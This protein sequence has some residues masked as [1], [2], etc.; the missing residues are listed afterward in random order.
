MS[1]AKNQHKVSDELFRLLI[2]SVSDYAIYMIG[3]DGE[4]LTWNKGAEEIKGY[5]ADEIIGKNFSQF[6]TQVDQQA[7]LPA[8]E[9]KQA[10]LKGR[11]EDVAWRVRKDNTQFFAKISITPLYN[12]EK[13]LRG[14]AKITRDMTDRKNSDDALAKLK[15]EEEIFRPLV[16]SVL[17][18]AII[19]LNPD[20]V[21]I[22]WNE[23]AKRITGYSADEIT[24]QS[25]TR[26]Y[27]IEATAAGKPLQ[28]LNDAGTLGRFDERGWRVRQDGSQFFAHITT[29]PLRDHNG[30]L[31]GFAEVFRDVT[32]RKEYED[33]QVQSRHELQM[34]NG[35]LAL[36]RDQAQAASKYKS[37]F[38]ANMSHEI[39]TPLN[40]IIGMCNVLLT[41]SMSEAQTLYARAI[42]TA[43]NSLLTIINDILDFS[44]IEAGR[45]DLERTDFSPVKV[46]ET[47]C[48]ILAN[49]AR[50]KNLTL[51]SFIDPSMPLRLRGDQE[52]VQQIL[53][54]FISNA[55]KFSQSGE[56]IVKAVVQTTSQDKVNVRF[57]VTDSG[58]GLTQEQQD[59]LFQPFMQADGTINRRFG[60]TGLGLSISKQLVE[61]MEGTIGIESIKDSGSTFWFLVPFECCAPGPSVTAQ[62][63][64]FGVRSL[65]VDDEP[66][67]REIVHH[68]LTSWGLR[69]DS[70][71]TVEAGM[72]LLRA[73][74]EQNDP[75]KIVIL[76]LSMPHK[77]GMDMAK[78]VFEDPSLNNVH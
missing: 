66:N 64:L 37:E 61:L 27:T 22:T 9:L 45:I 13:Q 62:A 34:L 57:S 77:N 59:K 51:M 76:D 71:S 56:V 23:G 8:F 50:Q 16:S 74:V 40:G 21:I 65:N 26:L 69:N 11:F 6:Y 30:L 24:G 44:K 41:T 17:D 58:I 47:A 5:L 68:Y 1:P 2:T 72:K 78:E 36:A 70:V 35:E 15:E 73:G 42:K 55:I 28:E 19:V 38:V 43:G 10:Q 53:I 31:R 60:G 18:Y 63:E 67:S 32:D 14:F 49:N 48:E 3:P 33:A 12:K 39:R 54:N 4:V 25:F 52:R 20:G 29:T 75:Y 7:G 46:V